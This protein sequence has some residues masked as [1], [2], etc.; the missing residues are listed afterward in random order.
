MAYKN[1]DSISRIVRSELHCWKIIKGSPDM[2]PKMLA[3]LR[4]LTKYS[5]EDIIDEFY[6]ERYPSEVNR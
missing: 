5:H 4:S 3:C 6:L 2:P 1:T